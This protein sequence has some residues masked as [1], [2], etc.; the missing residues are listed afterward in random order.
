[1]TKT[2]IADELTPEQRELSRKYNRLCA[3][4]KHREIT[5][6]MRAA[7]RAYYKLLYAAKNWRA[8]G[9]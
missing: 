1:M 6:E 9:V 8:R 7:K 5:E 2:V 4:R 3:S